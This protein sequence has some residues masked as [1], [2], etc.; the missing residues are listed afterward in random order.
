M[1]L[2]IKKNEPKRELRFSEQADRKRKW[3]TLIRTVIFVIVVMVVPFLFFKIGEIFVIRSVT[4]QNENEMC[5][6]QEQQLAD[7]FLGKRLW[8]RNELHHPYLSVQV[9][10]IFPNKVQ[11][12]FHKQELLVS[13]SHEEGEPTRS[14]TKNGVVVPYGENMINIPISDKMVS[15]L[16]VGEHV[17]PQVLMF[18]QVLV[19]FLSEQNGTPVQL[20]SI[21]DENDVYIALDQ[22]SQ[23]LLKM[24]SIE[25]QLRSLQVLVNT[26]TIDRRGKTIDL[27]FSNPVIK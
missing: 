3:Q 25:T 19:R 10:K 11:V 6:L 23:A 5:G 1:F 16:S 12:T 24:E 15:S 22:S 17:R 26:P 21:Q 18:Y 14:I 8:A 7:T 13:F 9:K 2:K 27:R 20:V 4:C